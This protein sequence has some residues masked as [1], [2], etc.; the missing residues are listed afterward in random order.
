[1]RQCA[2]V[3]R[4]E[5]LEADGLGVDH[6]CV[7]LHESLRLPVASVS[8]LVNRVNISAYL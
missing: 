5:L 6:G 1:M 8:S 2:V 4:V 7:A 3:V